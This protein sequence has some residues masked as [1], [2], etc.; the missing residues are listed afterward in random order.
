MKNRRNRFLLAIVAFIL[1]LGV[2]YAAASGPWVVEGTATA[3]ASELDVK[4]TDAT[5]GANTTSAAF[6]SDVLATMAVE[7]DEIGE[8]ATAT[9]TITNA[10]KKGIG[11]EINPD[12]ITVTYGDNDAATSEYFE[13]TKTLTETELASN[14]GSTT[15]TVTVKLL[16]VNDFVYKR[17]YVVCMKA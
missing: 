15:L 16:K 17:L 3:K 9:F 14:G 10:S 11:A 8:E 4:F 5:A 13:V 7:L 12:T 1:V 2:G 6:S